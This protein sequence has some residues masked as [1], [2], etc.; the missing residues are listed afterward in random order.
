M[1][2]E[3]SI[4]PDDRSLPALAEITQKVGYRGANDGGRFPYGYKTS[5]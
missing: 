5:F 2:R 1:D 3:P 4:N